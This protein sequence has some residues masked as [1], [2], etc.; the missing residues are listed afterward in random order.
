VLRDLWE[1]VL[2][3]FLGRYYMLEVDNLEQ[4]VVTTL[5]AEADVVQT[6]ILDRL[7]EV[8]CCWGI[9]SFASRW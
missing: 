8:P 3:D 4:P 9:C 7:P 6:A 2:T 5:L 1:A